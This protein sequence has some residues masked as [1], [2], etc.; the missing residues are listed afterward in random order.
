M[1]A[2]S[3]PNA[4]TPAIER[5]RTLL[6]RPFRWGTFLKLSLVAVITEGV[7][8]NFNSSWNGGRHGH[9]PGHVPVIHSPFHLAPEWIAAIVA[10]LLLMIVLS[11]FLYYLI[12]RLRFAFFHCLIHNTKE[13]RP[14]WQLYRAQA[15]R[16]FWL[17]IVVGFC[18]LAVVVLIAL[19][20][21]A[22]F[23]RLYQESAGGG[24]LDLE[25]LFSLILP[26]IPI[27]LL[28]IVAGFLADLILRDLMLPHYALD[29]ATAGEAWTAVWARIRSEKGSFSLY[30]LL[31][32]I[33]PIAAAMAIVIVMI[34]PAIL[35]ALVIAA[36]VIGIHAG[37]S[38]A[39]GAS[40]V[41]G[42]MAEVTV[43]LIALAIVVLAAICVGGPLSTGIREFAL[44][45]YG[46]RYQ[47]LGDIL[48]PPAA[49]VS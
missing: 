28:L 7:G 36:L 14:G 47:R 2:L 18:F 32:L 29:N 21:A 12:T 3:A 42:I 49:E 10:M 26:L 16:F 13:I 33:L 46:G 19:P 6:F 20:F 4:I 44:L 27:V 5:T 37:M 11:C 40:A 17:N 31:R 39:T 45:F 23:W 30:A 25:L 38:G 9:A 35:L 41:L 48:F 1:Q 34:V 22:G 24:K 15:G 8:G 43:G